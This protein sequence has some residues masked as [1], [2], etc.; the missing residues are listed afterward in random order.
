MY[1]EG[2][3][4]QNLENGSIDENYYSS[5]SEVRVV[6]FDL[7]NCLWKTGATISAANDAL[8]KFL[9]EHDIVQPV[10][11]EN[12]MGELFSKSKERYSPNGGKAP[13]LLTLLRKDAIQQVLKEHNDYSEEDAKK[14][15]AEAFDV[16]TK[17]RHNV[18]PAHFA[19]SVVECLQQ[20]RNM[21]TSSGK[22]ILIGA[23]TDGNSDPRNVG[24]LSEFFDFVVNAESVGHS[25]PS[26]Q[27]YMKAV[28]V[29]IE[30]PHVEDI[31][32][33]IQSTLSE[34]VI[35]DILGPWWVHIGDDFIKDVVPA[36]ELK[37]RSIWA[38]ELILPKMMTMAKT[39]DRPKKSME[40]FVKEVADKKVIEAE[41]GAD[42]YLVDSLQKEFADA[43]VDNFADI[44]AVLSAW[45]QSAMQ[46][47]NARKINGESIETEVETVAVVEIPSV[48][49]VP[50]ADRNETPTNAE[51]ETK[52]FC[53]HC[54][55]KLP[56]TAKFCSVCGEK[57]PEMI[58]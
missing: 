54:G 11:A 37:I 42:D 56:M 6:T 28:D 58:A 44:S 3:M 12:I 55:V 51:T 7:D 38:R 32:G 5:A 8:A 52:K 22:P 19:S 20:V 39:V 29:V 35:E 57:Q 49:Q 21:P 14:L 25:K 31:F 34:D 36:K 30:H 53:M 9:E 16:W 18:I 2:G 50:D 4:E 48:H 15:A 13:V 33:P 47:V 45:Q 43:V 23:V 1:F 10:R 17:A 41:I 26:K 27:L 46:K 24:V 40:A